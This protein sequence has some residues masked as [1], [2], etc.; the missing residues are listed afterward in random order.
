MK[1]LN[2]QGNILP[3]SDSE[4]EYLTSMMSTHDY[5]SNLFNF[6]F[7]VIKSLQQTTNVADTS[8]VFHNFFIF[9]ILI[10]GK[11]TAIFTAKI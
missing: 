3:D 4:H 11:E 9:T 1:F 10:L 5:F 7:L 8:I 2:G 6:F